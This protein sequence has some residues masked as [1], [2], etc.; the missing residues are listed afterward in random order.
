LIISHRVADAGVASIGY[1]YDPEKDIRYMI[2]GQTQQIGCT[3]YL[4]Y[5]R[6]AM[7]LE[8][9]LSIRP[10][11]VVNE[12]RFSESKEQWFQSSHFIRTFK[13][14]LLKMIETAPK[15]IEE[16][17]ESPD[18]I[19]GQWNEATFQ[20]Y[21]KEMMSP[22]VRN[23]KIGFESSDNKFPYEELHIS[24][25]ASPL[26]L[27]KNGTLERLVKE[28]YDFELFVYLTCRLRSDDRTKKIKAS[29]LVVV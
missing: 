9:Y 13:V 27:D 4:A 14:K 11:T 19:S 1:Q 16:G 18:A 8:Q 25:S 3:M 12:L 15:T 2:F 6:D 20:T 5:D 29:G 7:E 10:G 28:S 22:P 26:H 23:W 21:L 17:E 24:Y